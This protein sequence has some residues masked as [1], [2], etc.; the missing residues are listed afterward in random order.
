MPIYYRDNQYAGINAHLHSILQNDRYGWA[1]FH[2]AHIID[3]ARTLDT[4][5]PEGYFALPERS[6]Q[7]RQ[8]NGEPDST[9][10]QT[11]R[12]DIAIIR[13]SQ[14]V[15]GVSKPSPVANPTLRLPAIEQPD[16]DDDFLTA[17]SIRR[18]DPDHRFGQ[19]VTWLELLSPTNKPPHSGYRQYADKRRATLEAG[20]VL[21]ELD[22]LHESHPI[23]PRIPSYANRD[24]NA[25]PY[26]IIITDPRPTLA[27]AEMLVYGFDVDAPVPVL[28]VPLSL[29][30]AVTVDFGAIYNATYASLRAYGQQVDYAQQ[31]VNWP[32]Y[33]TPD[34][35]RI[36]ARM[37]AV[38]HAQDK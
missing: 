14:Q 23:E 18:V 6:M 13:Q 15:S 31:P 19:P 4:V 3:I 36:K 28:P 5:L 33:T 16:L 29:P 2:G 30:D 21:V 35:A 10:P 27:D 17:V 20:L 38:Q 25:H 34:Q 22:Y 1:T 11:R 9:P 37:Q 26:M 32:A 8:A 12:P 24:A 7:I